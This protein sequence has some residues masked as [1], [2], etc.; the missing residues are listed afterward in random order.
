[1]LK[2]IATTL[3]ILTAGAPL[4]LAHEYWI[5]P[6]VYTIDPSEEIEADL[7]NGQ[8]FKG[9]RYSFINDRFDFFKITG[10]SGEKAV[11]GRNGDIPA[12]KAKV[13]EDGLYSSSLQGNFDRITF[14]KAEKIKSYMD[15]E[16]FKGVLERHQERGFALNRFQEQ[17]ARCAKALFQ[18][19][20]TSNSDK[21]GLTG[22]KFELVAEKNPY[23]LTQTDLLPV[24]LYW[25][26]APMGDVQI[27]M[28]R[29]DGD[30]ETKIVRT[31]KNGRASFP[32]KGGGKFM[33]NAV[34]IFEGDDDPDT[35]LAEWVSYWASLTFGMSDTDGVLAETVGDPN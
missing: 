11:T 10:P 5:E 2:K 29:Y 26:G 27:R 34:H 16:G 25:E 18:V 21:D 24:R 3:F 4:A 31:D 12:L 35:R 15:Y 13:G 9:S 20:S 7:K 8:H 17:Y 6:R 33:L 14:N 28:F 23:Q 22:L 1:M 19:G 32:L 30:L